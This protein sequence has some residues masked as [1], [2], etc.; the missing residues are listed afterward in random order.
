MRIKS[1]VDEETVRLKS[2][3]DSTRKILEAGG[4]VGENLV[5]LRRR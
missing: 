4:S 2:H 5:L 3:I 1:L